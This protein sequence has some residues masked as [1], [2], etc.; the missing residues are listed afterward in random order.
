[1]CGT[2]DSEHS[3]IGTLTLHDSVWVVSVFLMALA[4]VEVVN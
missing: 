2:I 3:I 4:D 1:M